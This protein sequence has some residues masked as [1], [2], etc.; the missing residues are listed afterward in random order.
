[1]YAHALHTKMHETFIEETHV[2]MCFVKNFLASGE[3]AGRLLRNKQITD[4]IS[5]SFSWILMLR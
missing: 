1:M 5:L 2:Y 3:A 4:P